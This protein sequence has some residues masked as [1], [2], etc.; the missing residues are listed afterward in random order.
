MKN[1]ATYSYTLTANLPCSKCLV[2]LA[3]LAV[4][5]EFWRQGSVVHL[6][7]FV[8]GGRGTHII[9]SKRRATFGAA[10]GYVV[11]DSTIVAGGEQARESGG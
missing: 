11:A 9:Q 10:I 1:A 6:L 5:Q 3:L 4:C 2:L 7:R 8:D